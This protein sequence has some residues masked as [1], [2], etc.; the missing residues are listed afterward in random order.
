MRRRDFLAGALA[1]AALPSFAAAP[2]RP[3]LGFQVYGVRDLCERDFPGTLRAARAIG[4]EGVETGRFYGR[5]ASE[6]KAICADAGLELFALQLYP[7]TLA[8][9]ELS[10]TIR[11]A[12]EAGC[13]RI[14]V[15]WFQ[16][17]AV[18][19]RPPPGDFP[20]PGI[21]PESLRS[22]A[23]GRQVLY[24]LHHLGSPKGPLKK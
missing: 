16:G 24:H 13:C 6:L 11:F 3:R 7:W 10:K 18:N 14:N 17:S 23:I 19:E 22:L 20:N 4:Y 12:H 1:C 2:R 9:A 8:G 15:A 5:S 21:K